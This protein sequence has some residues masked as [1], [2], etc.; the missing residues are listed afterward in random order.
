MAT[1]AELQEALDSYVEDLKA[2][3]WPATNADQLRVVLMPNGAYGL[4]QLEN[5][6]ETQWSVIR[7][8]GMTKGQALDALRHLAFGFAYGMRWRED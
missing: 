5:D 6:D 1:K 8:L 7:V 2:G 4:T 3:G